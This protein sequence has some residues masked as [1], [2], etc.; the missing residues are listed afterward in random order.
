MKEL[1]AAAVLVG[2]V[3]YFWTKPPEP[4]LEPR[5]GRRA[6]AAT[7]AATAPPVNTPTRS[8]G[9]IVVAPNTDGSIASRW[10][11]GANAQTNL[12]AGVP[13]RWKTG[14]NAQTDLSAT[15]PDRWKPG[16]K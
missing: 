14:P 13:D 12:T 16:P 9:S 1:I 3:V 8:A 7:A 15:A 2:I 11:R 6:A 5:S 4:T 10:A